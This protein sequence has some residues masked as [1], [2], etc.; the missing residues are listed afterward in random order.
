MKKSVHYII[1]V[2]LLIL[3]LFVSTGQSYASSHKSTIPPGDEF[4]RFTDIVLK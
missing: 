4:I 1:A 3:T 2:M